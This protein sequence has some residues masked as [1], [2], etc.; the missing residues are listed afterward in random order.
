MLIVNKL[1]NIQPKNQGVEKPAPLILRSP[2]KAVCLAMIIGLAVGL[3]LGILVAIL[4]ATAPGSSTAPTNSLQHPTLFIIF[5]FTF[6]FGI[7]GL[8]LGTLSWILAK[9]QPKKL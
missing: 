3:I 8:M 2:A 6:G 7:L 1:N 9:L 5:A 4:N